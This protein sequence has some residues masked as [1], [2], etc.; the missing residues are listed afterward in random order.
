VLGEML[1]L[2]DAADDGHRAVG[3]AAA[4]TA[5]WLVVVGEGASGIADGA[6]AAGLDPA[7]TIRVP[8][9]EAALDVV[10]DR[11]RDGDVVLLKASRGIGLDR[12]VDGL[13]HGYGIG[14]FGSGPAGSGRGGAAG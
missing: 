3:E 10:T 5:D 11:L 12:V 2:G 9:A 14:A 13:R 8:D 6:E 1:E 4:R 7:R